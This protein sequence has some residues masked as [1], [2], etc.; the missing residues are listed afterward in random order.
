MKKTYLDIENDW[1]VVEN[2]YNLET[3]PNV[4]ALLTTGNGY[5]GVRGSFEEYGSLRVQGCYI[6]GLIDQI[7]ELPQPFADN[8]YMKKYYLHEDKLKHFEKQDSVINFADIL[9]VRVKIGGETFYPWEGKVLFWKRTLD[10]KNSRLIREVKW[11][12]SQGDITS[13]RFERFSSFD[14]DHIYCIKV[15]ITPENHNKEVEILS[16]LDLRTKTNGQRIPKT[17][18]SK[19]SE[20]MIIH[21]A[22]A[23]EAYKFIVCTGV[24]N[25][26]YSTALA[27]DSAWE[28]QNDGELLANKIS[29]KANS[30][31]TYS[32][33]KKIFVI[34]SRDTDGQ[35]ENM[36]S[37]N[38]SSMKN[39]SYSTL[40]EKHLEQWK[41]FF[42]SLD[43]KIKGDLIAD[44]SLRFSNYHTA[45]SIGRNDYVHSLGAKGLTG[46]IYNDFVWWDCEV[47]QAPPFFYTVPDVAKN[48]LMY[49][50][51]MLDSARKLAADEGRKGARFPFTSSVTG[52]ETVWEYV[53]HP[54]MQIH[55]VADVAWGVI[56]YYTSTGDRLFMTE[57]GLEMLWE[58]ARYWTSRVELNEKLNRYEIKTVTG[59]DEHHPYVDNNAYTNYLVWIVLNYATRM[60][61][62]FNVSAQRTI[63]EIGITDAEI[64][65]WGEIA[66]KLYLPIDPVT[67]MIPQFDNYFSLNKSLEVAGGSAAKDFQMKESG[68]Y[69]RSQVIK[70]PDVMLLF[71]YINLN[72]DDAIYK[73]NWDY[74]QARCEASSSLSYP[75][76]SICASD[77]GQP[78]SAYK[79]FLKSARLDMD[80]EHHCAWQGI[81]SACA[82]GAWLAVMRGV[83]GIKIREN[84]LEINPHMIPWWE[85]VS[86]SFTWHGKRVEIALS[87]STFTIKSSESNDGNIPVDFRGELHGLQA[88][89]ELSFDIALKW[90][91]KV[92]C[93]ELING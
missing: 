56:N 81:H 72:F 26:I 13:L 9:F 30:G 8:I 51:K 59:T 34:T 89:Q 43:M 92:N 58:A 62:E 10:L 42:G 85:E 46:E 32:L 61:K 14:N 90:N 38:L 48:V 83:A 76:H 25:D 45:I 37:E 23:G 11:E 33:E 1:S 12:N 2:E 93:E 24:A 91:A 53:R 79:Y 39:T 44:T 19:V 63:S 17:I 50:Y 21:S 75:V 86:F 22:Y 71:S 74:Y 60:F 77:M 78:E 87:N 31:A 80:D 57:Y 40:F 20:D 70:Q 66:D 54:F 35:L 27:F 65:Q 64:H 3:E 5:I 15:D 55:I 16:G 28:N 69:H 29:F 88:G 67:G 52:L 41:K 47:Y 68:L 18:N 7:Y 6:R 84:K 49:R 36:V 82:A 73:R 4:A